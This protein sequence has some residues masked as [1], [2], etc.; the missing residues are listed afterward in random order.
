M[1]TFKAV[2]ISEFINCFVYLSIFYSYKEQS[3]QSLTTENVLHNQGIYLAGGEEEECQPMYSTVNK[4]KKKVSD[5][6]GYE[7]TNITEQ[8][9][10]V[11]DM[12]SRISG[13]N[14]SP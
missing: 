8:E 5:E 6:P 10:T 11:C 2:F 14:D 13:N 4:T 3:S 7:Q 9:N 12:D 1:H